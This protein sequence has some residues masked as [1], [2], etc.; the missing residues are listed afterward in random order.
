[1]EGIGRR[2]QISGARSLG[3]LCNWTMHESGEEER[4]KTRA[5]V[6]KSLLCLDHKTCKFF[7]LSEST[8]EREAQKKSC[9]EEKNE[10]ES[11]NQS[12]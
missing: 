8:G 12:A 10:L 3:G 4:K 2:R 7:V 9:V 1:M 6:I 11:V 5:S